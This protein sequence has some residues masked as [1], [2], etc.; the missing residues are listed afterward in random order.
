VLST[1]TARVLLAYHH[2]MFAES[3]HRVLSDER[4][5]EVVGTAGSSATAVQLAEV[6]QPSVAIVEDLLPDADGFLTASSIREVS[7]ATRVLLLAAMSD[8]QLVTSAV[9]AGCSGFLTKT[10]SVHEL[11]A[12]VHLAHS[13]AAY[14]PPDI[15]ATMLPRLD[16]CYR[17]LGS[18]LTPREREILR[19]M[20][21]GGLG[22]KDIA[23]QLQL[24]HHTVRNHVQNI[25]G[26]L[27]AHS[28]LQAVVIAGREGLMDQRMLA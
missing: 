9:E 28:K 27:G 11:V 22:N 26:K 2:G 17:E 3:L 10:K 4:Q 14:L 16:R 1:D 18:D 13:G 21:A 19:L 6:L 7:P 15:L 8:S 20:T 24:S 25:L 23:N 12:A 5:I